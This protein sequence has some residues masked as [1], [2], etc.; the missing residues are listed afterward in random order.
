MARFRSW[1]YMLPELWRTL[2]RKRT[3]VLYP[4]G[5]LELPDS[6]RGKVIADPEL[7]IGCGQCVRDC[8]ADGLEL[9]RDGRRFTL[10]LRRDRCASCGQCEDSC[11]HGAISMAPEYEPAAPD[12]EAMCV[13]LV[14]KERKSP[15]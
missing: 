14:D 7:C 4:F 5:E 10:I 13:V 8:P 15:S 12:R 6:Y 9:V 3:T 11:R 2:A 1:S